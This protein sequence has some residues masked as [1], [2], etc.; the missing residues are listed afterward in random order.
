MARGGKSIASNNTMPDNF[1]VRVLLFI[2]T[3]TIILH[4]H[5]FSF[6]SFFFFCFLMCGY[7]T[8]NNSIIIHYFSLK[9]KTIY[10]ESCGFVKIKMKTNIE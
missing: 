8:E 6:F 3:S 10:Y 1:S 4:D 5:L 7:Q 2:I 9:T